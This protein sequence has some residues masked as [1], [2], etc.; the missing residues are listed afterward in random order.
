MV[1]ALALALLAHQLHKQVRQ[2]VIPAH[3]H[4]AERKLLMVA[5]RLLPEFHLAGEAGRRSQQEI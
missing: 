1:V 5:V 4:L 2:S 3:L